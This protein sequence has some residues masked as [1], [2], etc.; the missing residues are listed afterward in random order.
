MVFRSKID[1][2]FIIIMAIS[3]SLL[4][5][6]LFIPF[7]MDQY[8]TLIDGVIVACLF[9]FASGII[10]WSAFFIK[11]ELREQYL[12]VRGGPFKGRIPYKDIEKVHSTREIFAGYRLLSAREGLEVFYKTAGLGSVKISPKEQERFL[13]ELEKRCPKINIQ[14]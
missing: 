4:G 2:F 14:L 3:V 7:F 5:A 9:L 11:Y 6:A 12:F 1:S 10:L 8:K 13:L